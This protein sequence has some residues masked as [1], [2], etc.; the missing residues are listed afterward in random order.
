MFMKTAKKIY[1]RLPDVRFVVVG[2]DQACYGSDERRTGGLTYKQWV[3]A[4]DAYDLSKFAFVGYLPTPALAE[5]LAI[6]DL[7][8]YLTVPFVLSWSLMDALA[9]GAL[10]VASGTPPVCEMIE[11]G[12]T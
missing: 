10:V 9:C 1:E 3:L 5:L 8:I 4:Q 7:H 12:T 6:S 11:H 2:Q